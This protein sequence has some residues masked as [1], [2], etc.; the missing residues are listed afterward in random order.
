MG[1]GCRE[2]KGERTAS[3]PSPF[4]H[5][6]HSG[7]REASR[8]ATASEEC[9]TATWRG[10]SAFALREISCDSWPAPM[11]NS[12]GYV[13]RL[14]QQYWNA[15]MGEQVL[16]A[17]SANPSFAAR[18]RDVFPSSLKSGLRRYW[19]LFLTIRL[20]RVRSAE[21]IAR[22]MRVGTSIMIEMCRRE[23]GQSLGYAC[24]QARLC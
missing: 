7:K 8:R 24:H 11:R 17:M 13:V 14:E 3:A 21:W 16:T 1:A 22:R 5:G 12:W 10:V 2:G 23:V 20:R 18:W 6:M 9:E 15:G 4:F 19:G